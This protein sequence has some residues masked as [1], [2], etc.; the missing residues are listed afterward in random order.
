MINDPKPMSSKPGPAYPIGVASAG[1]GPLIAR[2]NRRIGQW[3]LEEDWL[4]HTG[5]LLAR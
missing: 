2:G 5:R 1:Q 4:E 3:R